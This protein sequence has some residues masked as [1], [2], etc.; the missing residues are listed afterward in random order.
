M[1]SRELVYRTLD[2]EMQEGDRIPRHM[3][4]LPWAE[5][6]HPGAVSALQ[7]EFPDDICNAPGFQTMPVNANVT[8]GMFAVGTYIDE[9]GCIFE[10]KQS[11][12]IG[13][14]KTPIVE[15]WDDTSKVHIPEEALSID[16]NQVNAFCKETDQ[17]V[18]AG[19]CQRPFERLQFIRGTE[20]LYMDLALEDEGLDAFLKQ[21]HEFHLKELEVWSK[22]DVD[23]LFIM[24]DWGTQKSLLINPEMWRKVF[25]PLYKDYITLAHDAGKRIFM[26]T[27]GYIVDIYPDLIKLGLDAINS[28]VFCMTPETLSQ[29]AGQITFWGEMDRQWIL[30]EGTV[31]EVELAVERVYENLFKNGGVIGQCEFGPGAKPENVHALYAAWNRCNQAE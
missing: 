22:T 30:P 13:E 31:K 17:F 21:M 19:A 25:K 12:I 14:V 2:F 15:D 7:Q 24:D 8:G 18:V 28:Q 3:W 23:A 27:D 20:N 11:G 16:I 5:E 26:H 29:F 4:W 6:N 10:N 9:W 1:T